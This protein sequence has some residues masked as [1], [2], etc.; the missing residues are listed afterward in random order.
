MENDKK[1]KEILDSAVSAQDNLNQHFKNMQKSFTS[2]ES[3]NAF[4]NDYNESKK[5]DQELDSIKQK[6]ISDY[7][8]YL[9][10]YGN[11]DNVKLKFWE[12][13]E[14]RFGKEDALREVDPIIAQKYFER[15]QIKQANIQNEYQ[16]KMDQNMQ[17]REKIEELKRQKE[18]LLATKAKFLTKL[19]GSKKINEQISDLDKEITELEDIDMEEIRNRFNSL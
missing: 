16:T 18:E 9:K 7:K 14:D 5:I 11:D 10:E 8:E 1:N 4:I 12:D 6:I 19:F 17:R 13:I 3:V 2:D 15:K